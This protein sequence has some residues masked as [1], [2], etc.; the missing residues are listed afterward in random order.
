MHMNFLFPATRMLI[1]TFF[2]TMAG[3]ALAADVTVQPA[4]SSGFVVKD[5]SGANERLRVQEN[6]AITLPGITGAAAQTQPLCVGG[7]GLLGLCSGSGS[8]YSAGA[9]LNLAG[10]VFSIAPTYQLPQTCAANQ[11]AQ[12]NGTAWNCATFSATGLPAGTANQT[13]RYDGGNGL[14]ATGDLQVMSDGGVLATNAAVNAALAAGVTPT[15]SVPVSG[16]GARMMWYPAKAAFRAGHV[17]TDEWDDARIGNAS[18]AFGDGATAYGDNS[19]AMGVGTKAG[20]YASTAMGYFTATTASFSTAMGNGTSASGVSST[21]MGNGTTA[22]GVN[23]IAMGNGTTANGNNSAALGSGTLSQ[24]DSSIAAGNGSMAIGDYS[25]AIGNGAHTNGQA[26]V[27][28]GASNAVGD[29][30]FASGQSIAQGINSVAMG[31]RNLAVDYSTALGTNSSADGVNSFV[32]G[33]GSKPVFSSRANGTI[34]NGART[35]VVLASGGTT[36]YSSSQSMAGY[37]D[38]QESWPGV[39]LPSGSGG[40]SNLSDRAAKDEFASVD[41]RTILDRVVALPMTT[42]RYRSQDKSIRHIGAIAQDFYAAFKLG[43]DERHISTVDADGVAL[44][45]IQGLNAKLIESD[46]KTSLLLKDKDRE[47][48]E[49]RK[50]LDVQKVRVAELEAIAHDMTE[51]KAQLTALRRATQST[52]VFSAE[53]Q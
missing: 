39:I 9:G 41:A 35:F 4:S 53:V 12:W 1:A 40:W 13:L 3:V 50:D 19:T 11:L 17:F 20:G 52:Q 2:F 51:M 32:F 7:G 27:A 26:S 49:L 44:A 23:S 38:Q 24:G 47:I 45:A 18:I 36:I 28:T 33:D 8:S 6:G 29:Y 10:S 21:A 15:G 48:A 31:G 43:E 14:T 30:S 25:L 22:S 37:P 5:A 46:V 34:G 42:W 16:S